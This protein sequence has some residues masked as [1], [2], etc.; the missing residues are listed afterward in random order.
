M[1]RTEPRSRIILS[2]DEAA[3]QVRVDNDGQPGEWIDEAIKREM[4]QRDDLQAWAQR[5]YDT[6]HP[7]TPYKRVQH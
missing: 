5:A 2:N 6:A 3:Q 1:R 7:T 4:T